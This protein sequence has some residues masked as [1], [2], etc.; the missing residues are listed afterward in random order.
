MRGTFALVALLL[1]SLAAPLVALYEADSPVIQLTEADFDAKVMETSD[2]LWLIEFYA[3]WCG[4]CKQLAPIYEKVAKNLNGMV[5]VAAVDC[6]ENKALATKLGVRGYP[7]IKVFPVE[8]SFNPYTKKHAKVPTDYAGPR[9]AK[10]MVDSVLALLPDLVHVVRAENVTDFLADDY[11]KAL[12]FTDK[13]AISSLYKSL[14]VTFS[15]RIRVGQAPASDTA[16]AAQFGVDTFPALVA[17][18]GQDPAAATKHT[19]KIKKDD[20]QAF[21]GEHALKDVKPDPL[22]AAKKPKLVPAFSSE[23]FLEKVMA[24]KDLWVILFHGKGKVPPVMEELGA[25]LKGLKAASV[26]CSVAKDMCKEQ[27]VDTLPTLRLFSEDKSD[28]EDFTGAADCMEDCMEL[29]AMSEWVAEH[30]P[31]VVKAVDEQT[32]NQFLAG[33]VERPVVILFSKKSEPTPLYKAVALHFKGLVQF[34]LFGNPAKQ[35]TEQMQIKKL[36]SLMVFFSQNGTAESVQGMP[37]SGP[38][39]YEDMVPFFEQFATP[40]RQQDPNAKKTQAGGSTAAPTGPVPQV[41]RAEGAGFD[42]LCGN[43][44]GLCAIAFLDGSNK[45]KLEEQLKVLEGTRAKKHPS[46]YS[47]AWVDAACHRDFAS[48]LDITSDKLPTIAVVSPSKSRVH[49]HVGKFNVDELVNTLDAVLSGKKSTT[50][51]SSLNALEERTC[52]EVHAET[53]AAMAGGG[54]EEEDDIMKEM[55]EE[56]RRKEAEAEEAAE[57]AEGAKKKKKKRKSKKK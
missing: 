51:Y 24:G 34:G 15:G 14:A 4:H 5:K 43:K 32:V 25:A 55:M 9:T 41:S 1:V 26:D 17:V 8:K 47:F 23:E 33:A 54:S 42:D 7:S 44:G 30:T 36:P 28:T 3:P 46:P 2:A 37:Y 6:D 11:P 18:P 48:S 27:G 35:V 53:E 56:I 52:A 57:A 40:F 19:G 13:E 49:T 20:L 10:G 39:T 38:A 50:P 21:L 31:N 16:L 12:L 29:E 45:E 22:R